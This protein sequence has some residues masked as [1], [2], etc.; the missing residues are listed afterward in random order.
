MEWILWVR[1]HVG[2]VLVLFVVFLPTIG[3]G[4]ED[5]GI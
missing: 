2:E 1:G 5:G 3:Q 4:V